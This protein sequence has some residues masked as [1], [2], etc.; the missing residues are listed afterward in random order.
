MKISSRNT[1]FL[2]LTV[3]IFLVI[4]SVSA[5]NIKVDPS[6]N[7][8]LNEGQ[9][10]DYSMLITGIPQQTA[11]IE[12]ETDLEPFNNTPLWNLTDSNRYGVENNSPLLMQKN[13][14][15]TPSTDIT[16][17]IIIK[18]SGKVPLVKQVTTYKGV[19]FTKVER[20]TGYLYYRVQPYDAKG[21]PVG[22]GDTKTFSISPGSKT[23]D[24]PQPEIDKIQDPEIKMITQ[25]LYDKGLWQESTRLIGYSNHQTEIKSKEPAKV[26][27]LVYIVS[28]VII[29]FALFVIG[30]RTKKCPKQDYEEDIDREV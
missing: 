28:I 5:L 9:N 22:V 10:I 14:R 29:G 30:Y 21:Y 24:D 26:T 7:L 15:L 16:T 3:L 12:L 27:L 1:L 6:L 20:I 25:D 8:I 18:V 2:L 19:V 23:G 13:L 17:P 4:P 11:F